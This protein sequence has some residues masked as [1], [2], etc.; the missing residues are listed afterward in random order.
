M[1][2]RFKIKVKAESVFT[3]KPNSPDVVAEGSDSSRQIINM[4]RQNCEMMDRY[5]NYTQQLEESYS[6]LYQAHLAMKKQFGVLKDYFKH[7]D[8]LRLKECEVMLERQKLIEKVVKPEHFF[9]A[10]PE[11]NK[12]FKT[13]KSAIKGQYYYIAYLKAVL[14]NNGIEYKKKQSFNTLEFANLDELIESIVNEKE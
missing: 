1:R 12:R 6:E 14:H 11:D 2:P 4:Y 9:N 5:A 7:P 3:V 10:R 8:D 13:Y